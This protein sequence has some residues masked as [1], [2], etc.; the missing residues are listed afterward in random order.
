MTTDNSEALR[1]WHHLCRF[2][3]HCGVA[4]NLPSFSFSSQIQRFKHFYVQYTLFQFLSLI[5]FSY[6]V[7]SP[8]LKKSVY[9]VKMSAWLR[10]TFECHLQML[11]GLWKVVACV[12]YSECSFRFYWFCCYIF[13]KQW[14]PWD[15]LSSY[16][17]LSFSQNKC[18]SCL[19][20][21]TC[22][23]SSSKS[24]R[25]H[26]LS[27]DTLPVQPTLIPDTLRQLLLRGTFT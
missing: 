5:L 7:T 6:S 14:N 27:G 21:W 23:L 3:Q 15:V 19:T 22:W 1:G 4:W 25:E 26:G 11:W 8:P 13:I 10:S 16:I 9:V 20:L 12:I 17:Y 24:F 18:T 2:N